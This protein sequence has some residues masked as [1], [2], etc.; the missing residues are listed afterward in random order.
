MDIHRTDPT[1]YGFIDGADA[2][3]W[4]V[5]PEFYATLHFFILAPLSVASSN[6]D[7]VLDS[8]RHQTK[9]TLVANSNSLDSHF[10]KFPRFDTYETAVVFVR[11]QP[12]SVWNLS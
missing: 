7:R 12:V 2:A 10:D 9:W 4:N 3:V 5:L 8:Y 1:T 11:L 6:N